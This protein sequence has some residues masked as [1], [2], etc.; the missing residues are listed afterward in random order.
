MLIITAVGVIDYTLVYNCCHTL[1][2]VCEYIPSTCRDW[3]SNQLVR[4]S[5]G[6]LVNDFYLC[7]FEKGGGVLFCNVSQE[8]LFFSLAICC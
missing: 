8:R 6:C 3:G 5:N 7:G 2:S 1:M 4:P